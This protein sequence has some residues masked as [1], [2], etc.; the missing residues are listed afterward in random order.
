MEWT[1]KSYWVDV[2]T[3]ELI[4]EKDRKLY[5]KIRVITK[6]TK[7]ENGEIRGIIEHRTECR[8]SN[9]RRI[10]DDNV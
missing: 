5:N 7:N 2:D 1:A 6:S 9:Q 4:K 8:R 10:W 3:G